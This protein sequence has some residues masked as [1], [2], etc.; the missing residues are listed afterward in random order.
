MRPPITSIVKASYTR[1]LCLIAG[2]AGCGP[3]AL[4][5]APAAPGALA[6][7][8][9]R[10]TSLLYATTIDGHGFIFAY[11]KGGTLATFSVATG[12]GVWGIC[13]DRN[14]DVFVTSQLSATASKIYEFAHGGTTPIATLDDDG[15][16]IADC[17]SDPV[18]GDLAV[19]NYDQT[20]SGGS[21]VAIYARARGTPRHLADPKMS[22]AFCGY[23]DD[24]NLF[25]DG[26]GT[27]QLAEL[28]KG[29][30][31]FKN[32]ALD[33]TIVGPGGVAWDGTELAIEANGFARKQAAI[34]RISVRGGKARIAGTTYL[35]GQANRGM[36]FW[37]G[38]GALLTAGGQQDTR[39]GLWPYPTGGKVSKLFRAH[40]IR[41]DALY[42]V[43]VSVAAR[44]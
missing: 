24:G 18:T 44:R 32:I 40:G 3:A 17:A 42:G 26:N 8:A 14:G 19:T 13:S 43:T 28:P 30:D 36:T 37:L 1:L 34:D 12:T 38:G 21:N 25:V 27:Y 41:G 7:P 35:H 15:Y 29:A 11:P 33:G 22:V 6:M 20:S 2:L 31:A 16:A 23:D 5:S 9:E 10:A 4:P 39:V